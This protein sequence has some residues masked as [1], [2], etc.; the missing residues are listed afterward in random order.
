MEAQGAR[1]DKLLPSDKA[2][3]GEPATSQLPS[4]AAAPSQSTQASDGVC[5]NR[6]LQA[7]NKSSAPQESERPVDLSSSRSTS[8]GVGARPVVEQVASGEV[9]EGLSDR[10]KLPEAH[11]SET[12]SGE[13]VT[14]VAALL[15]ACLPPDP[16]PTFASALEAR[17]D[18]PPLT[19]TGYVL[20]KRVAS[21]VAPP[22]FVNCMVGCLVG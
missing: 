10:S 13:A 7:P 17:P 22:E 3:T 5:Q 20:D 4:A 15:E 18:L 19:P 2:S 11:S 21:L 1:S 16:A 12:P 6:Q 14:A 9:K 8:E